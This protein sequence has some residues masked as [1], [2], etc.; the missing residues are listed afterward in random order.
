MREL[1]DLHGQA[2]RRFVVGF[3]VGQ[4]QLAEDLVQET[5]L[6]AW[7]NLDR[8]NP[9]VNTLLPWLLTVARRV[10]IDAAR[11]R[12]ARPM[13]SSDIDIVDLPSEGD[14]VN[15]VLAAQ[16]VRR[17]LPTLSQDHR[18]VVFALYYRGRTVA[19][20][21]QELGV[22]EG[23]VKSRAYYPLRALRSVIGTLDGDER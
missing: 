18:D 6:R 4:P 11:A 12:H 14:H 22:P 23:T 10:A 15:Q 5:M 16:T 17:A 21:A 13:S 1:Y 9:D 7:R 20:A 8:L 2:L 3:T 19:E